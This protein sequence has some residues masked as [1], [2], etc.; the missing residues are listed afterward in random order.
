MIERFVQSAREA[1][2]FDRQRERQGRLWLEQLVEGMLLER[3]AASEAVRRARPEL[4]AAVDAKQLT[5]LT[6]ARRIL[7]LLDSGERGGDSSS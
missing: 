3:L 6:A 1:G 5:P 7:A 2:D 4:E